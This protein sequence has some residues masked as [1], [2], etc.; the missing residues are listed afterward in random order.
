MNLKTDRD[1]A[2]KAFIKRFFISVTEEEFSRGL[3]WVKEDEQ[4]DKCLVFRRTIKDL[5]RHV[6]D[7]AG[8]AEGKN[9]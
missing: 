4:R 5:A 8:P 9:L 6:A 7:P 2:S 1:P 3:L